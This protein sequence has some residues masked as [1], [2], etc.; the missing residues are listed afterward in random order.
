MYGRTKTTRNLT[1]L[2][3]M[4]YLAGAAAGQIYVDADATGN[5]DGSSWVHAY[6]DLQDALTAVG[7][8]DEIRVA[9]GTYHPASIV[10]PNATF[11]LINAVSLMG[12]YAGSGEPDP[13]ARDVEQYETILSGDLMGNDL[14]VADPSDL[15]DEPTRADNSYHV[16][17]GSGTDETAVID[18]FTITAGNANG[19]SVVTNPTQ[20]PLVQGGGMYNQSGNPTVNNCIFMNNSAVWYGGGMANTNGSNP[21]ITNCKF[22]RNSTKDVNVGMYGNAGG[23]AI[24][25]F[26]SN[27]T[28][29]TCDF[30]DNWGRGGG[31]V[32]AFNCSSVLK[33][34]TFKKNTTV[35]SGGGM[36]NWDNC[37]PTLAHCR[38]LDNV[39]G[40]NGG[41]MYND[42]SCSPILTGCIFSG[43]TAVNGGGGILNYDSDPSLTN[44]V[45]VGNSANQGGGIRISSNSTL[46]MNNCILWGNIPEEISGS[47]IATVSYSDIQGG[48][49]GTGNMDEDPYFADPGY[50]HD[51]GTPNDPNDDFWFGGDYHLKSQA[52]RWNPNSQIWVQDE[53]TSPCID[54]G[55]PA[56]EYCGE[57]WPHGGR[58]NMGAY[59][60]TAEASI[61]LDDSKGFFVDLNCD[62]RVDI[63]DFGLLALKWMLEQRPLKED[64]DCNGQVGVNDVAILCRNWLWSE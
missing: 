42:I 4:I 37:N 62:G 52:G 57:S 28:F 19:A 21:I 8:G 11:Q 15:P 44:C 35:R 13:D 54:T 61:S 55:D 50:W 43:N 39:A 9:Q 49:S 6:N 38:F 24:N 16:V 31:M 32:N 47:G 56:L 18:G 7:P 27:P 36:Y 59:G 34:C 60:G 30:I 26:D 3:V 46:T 48:W 51:N 22:I 64:L 29:I 63:E 17:T 12:G 40:N 45:F 41:G 2:V 20:E 23:G 33:S 58:I 14:P 1:V 53:A 5:N 25:A 10:D